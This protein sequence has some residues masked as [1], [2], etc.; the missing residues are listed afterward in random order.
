M[1]YLYFWRAIAY[2]K[3]GMRDKAVEDCNTAVSLIECGKYY[4]TKDNSF[5]M[6]YS[7]RSSLQTG[8]L[9][10]QDRF[11]KARVGTSAP[12]LPITNLN[13][14]DATLAINQPTV[15]LY[16]NHYQNEIDLNQYNDLC[17]KWKGKV[18][19]C[20]IADS[21][22]EDLNKI[23]DIPKLTV[24]ILL[25]K[26]SEYRGIYN[27]VDPSLVIIDDQGIIRYNSSPFVII[28]EIDNYLVS[29]GNILP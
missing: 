23:F 13:G 24:P 8:V 4:S 27:Q 28:K 10:N 1:W 22:N 20:I 3:I 2:S 26:K 5:L 15:L 12:V 29:S 17:N 9:D 19:V 18:N 7:F 6:A 25:D 14:G 21:K 11:T 16:L